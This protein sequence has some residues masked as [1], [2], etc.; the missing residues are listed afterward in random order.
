[1]IA[2]VPGE[3][4]KAGLL[5]FGGFM[6]GHD[7]IIRYGDGTEQTLPS[8]TAAVMHLNISATTI[9]KYGKSGKAVDTK[10]GEVTI[11]IVGKE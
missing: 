10:F 4:N 11:K 9:R 8:V 6:R 5:L 1:M 2:K 7:V 3:E